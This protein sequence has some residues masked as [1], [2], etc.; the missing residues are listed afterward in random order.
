MLENLTAVADA[1]EVLKYLGIAT[2]TA[3][4]AVVT[5]KCVRSLENDERKEHI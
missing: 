4:T 2:G 3:T 1:L 5:K